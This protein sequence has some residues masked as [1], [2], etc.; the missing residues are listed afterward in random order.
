MSD[1]M[2]AD[3]NARVARIETARAK[4]Q[5]FEAD[6]TLGRSFYS[7]SDPRYRRKRRVPVVRP[8]LLALLFGTMVKALF[9][10]QIGAE[11]YDQRLAGLQEGQGIDRIGAFVMQIDPVTKA[12]ARQIGVFARVDR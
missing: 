8:V 1:P 11:A 3:F 5:G 4:G 12:L 2:I 9:L 6:G 10:H 7:Q